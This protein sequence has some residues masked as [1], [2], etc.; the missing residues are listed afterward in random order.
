MTQRAHSLARHLLRLLKNRAKVLPQS[1]IRRCL[2]PFLK[3]RDV[4]LESA[5]RFGTPQ[6]FF[7]EPALSA[8]IVKF[9]ETFTKHLPRFRVFYAIKSNSFSGICKS[10]VGSG[11][12]LDVSSGMEL[13]VALGLGCQH[14]I[15]SGPGKTD[16]ELR[17]AVS[18]RERVTILL[19]SAGELDRLSALIK[20]MGNEEESV[21]VGVRIR[22]SHHGIWNKFGVPL[23]QLATLFSKAMSTPGVKPQGFQFHTSWNLDPGPQV[24]MIKRVGNCIKDHISESSWRSLTFLDIGGG[25]WPEAGEWLNTANT[26]WGRLI[27]LFYPE[28]EFRTQHYYHEAKP[29]RDFAMRFGEAITQVGPPVSDLE[30]WME[31]GRWLSTPAMHILLK[32][33]DRKDSGMVVTDGGINLLGWERPLS[34]FIPVINLTRPSLKEKPFRI[35]GPLCTPLDIW[36]T[37]FFGDGIAP[38][39][40][41]LIPDQGAY[42][43]SLRQ[44][45]IKPRGRVIHYDGVSL[46]EVEKEG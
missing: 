23:D 14:V 8:R 25:Y 32:V 39:D 38:G 19:D 43:Y 20:E 9:R 27:H 30:I 1:A 22:G 42:T 46:K 36:G 2:D 7:D 16:E 26:L 33:I 31:P 37:S 12:G 24:E 15:F 34:E 3:K 28:W 35:F 10:A 11:I 13:S 29:L 4:F 44:S 45:F 6:Y 40:V 5:L 18:N 21:R 41:L 17:L